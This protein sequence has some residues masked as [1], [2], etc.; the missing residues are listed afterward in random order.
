MKRRGMPSEEWWKDDGTRATPAVGAAFLVAEAEIVPDQL[1]HSQFF[2]AWREETHEQA[3][4]NNN[5]S[6]RVE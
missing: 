2:P 6:R 5:M 3:S 4:R 1:F